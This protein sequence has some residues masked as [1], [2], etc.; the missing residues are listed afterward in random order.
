LWRNVHTLP[1]TKNRKNRGSIAVG[2]ESN[3]ANCSA[4]E[5]K[6][7]I[8]IRKRSGGAFDAVSPDDAE[9]SAEFLGEPCR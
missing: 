7:P 5:I 3:K 2:N 4:N 1:A 9:S 6:H 8:A